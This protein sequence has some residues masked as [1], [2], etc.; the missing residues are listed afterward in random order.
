[1]LSCISLRSL[2]RHVWFRAALRTVCTTHGPLVEISLASLYSPTRLMFYL[3]WMTFSGMLGGDLDIRT[4]SSP[5]RTRAVI[6]SNGSAHNQAKK[7]V[8]RLLPPDP[9]VDAEMYLST[10][11]LVCSR[12]RHA[13][14]RQRMSSL[15]LS[16]LNP[17]WHECVMPSYSAPSSSEES[18]AFAVVG[19]EPQFLG[20]QSASCGHPSL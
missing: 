5:V 20:P 7:I 2:L 14:M 17:C 9:G 6:C 10:S 19:L 4:L 12:D 13:F 3:R 15:S 11:V 16:R 18:M 8:D 1:M